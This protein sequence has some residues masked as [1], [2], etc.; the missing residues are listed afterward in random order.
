M[1]D[2]RRTL[3]AGMHSAN[4]KVWWKR[5]SGLGIGP[6]IPVKGNAVQYRHFRQV[7]VSNF[8]ATVWRRPLCTKQGP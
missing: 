2:A 1:V 5:V 3:A 8:V 7:D 6:F 4:S